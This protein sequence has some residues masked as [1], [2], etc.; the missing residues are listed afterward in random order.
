MNEEIE[1]GSDGRRMRGRQTMEREG[2]GSVLTV[3]ERWQEG[4]ELDVHPLRVE[5]EGVT[6]TVPM[7]N[8]Q[9][10]SSSFGLAKTKFVHHQSPLLYLCPYSV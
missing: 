10:F 1:K 5:E 2:S 6:S 4:K 3:V 9:L 7:R 8:K